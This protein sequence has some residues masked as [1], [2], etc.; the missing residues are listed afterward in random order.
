MLKLTVSDLPTTAYEVA[1]V[2]HTHNSKM[3]TLVRSVTL[4]HMLPNGFVAGQ[5]YAGN[6]FYANLDC[7]FVTKTQA[8]AAAAKD[9]KDK[10]CP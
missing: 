5:D 7:F 9:M 10:T 6:D 4:T 3:E 8:E 1:H 2:Y